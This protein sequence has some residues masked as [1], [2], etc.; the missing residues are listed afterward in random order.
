MYKFVLFL[1][2]E[3]EHYF[4]STFAPLL[5][6]QIAYIRTLN[7]PSHTAFSGSKSF[8]LAS[9]AFLP[10][11]Q[12]QS[13]QL[14]DQS[15]NQQQKLQM[16]ASRQFRKSG[17]R[18]HSDLHT[19]QLLP[20]THTRTTRLERSSTIHRFHRFV[21]H[22][23]SQQTLSFTLV[24]FIHHA[25]VEWMVQIAS[26]QM[27]NTLFH[28]V[29]KTCRLAPYPAH[30]FFFIANSKCEG[31]KRSLVVRLISLWFVWVAWVQKMRLTISLSDK[32]L[33]NNMSSAFYS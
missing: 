26:A 33:N 17:E 22:H 14:H 9:S 18:L 23:H 12:E 4:N 8:A 29:G 10:P 16:W 3:H 11:A 13:K 20:H 15:A 2:H 31:N 27:F 25:T 19:A 30:I 7:S 28:V 32:V 21:E 24:Q 6:L 5:A 1:W